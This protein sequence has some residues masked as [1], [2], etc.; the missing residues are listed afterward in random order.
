MLRTQIEVVGILAVNIALSAYMPHAIAQSKF[1][2]DKTASRSHTFPH[3]ADGSGWRSVL[4]VAN[5]T[6]DPSRCTLELHGMSVDRFEYGGFPASGSTATF[7]LARGGGYLIWRTRNESALAYGYGTLECTTPVVGQVIYESINSSGATTGAATV[8]SAEDGNRFQFPALNIYLGFV[9]ANDNDDDAACTFTLLDLNGFTVGTADLA[10]SR[11]S[12]LAQNLNNLF[13]VP[14]GFANGSATVSCNRSVSVVGLHVDGGVFTT[15]PP[16]VLSKSDAHDEERFDLF[17]E[18]RPVSVEVKLS[19]S[20]RAENIVGLTEEAMRR[21][22]E[23]RLR[24]AR[25]HSDEA[26]DDYLYVHVGHRAVRYTSGEVVATAFTVRSEFQRSVSEPRS[27][28]V[29]I[30]TTWR[31]AGLGNQGPGQ[32]ADFILNGV[33]Q[34][35]DDFIDEYLDVNRG[36]CR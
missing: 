19:R 1:A 26:T 11:K 5:P 31:N 7:E 9:I 17:N 13:A 6:D 10:I 25:L 4:L 15:L 12:N 30:A 21:T 23:R 3:I 20:G 24:S 36:A 14:S 34:Y 28:E 8:L 16:A 32:D 27:G 35:T 18:C 22:V 29:G 33:V 2:A